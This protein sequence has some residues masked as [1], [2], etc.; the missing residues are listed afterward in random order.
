MSAAHGFP[1]RPGASE[2]LPEQLQSAEGV[3]IGADELAAATDA[4]IDTEPAEAE[5]VHAEPPKSS[6]PSSH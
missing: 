3:A 1:S 4:V 6:E 5:D 2:A